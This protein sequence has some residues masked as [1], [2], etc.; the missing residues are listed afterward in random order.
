[1]LAAMI[2]DLDAKDANAHIISNS[3]QV[4]MFLRQLC[5]HRQHLQLSANAV[6]LQPA[7]LPL[8]KLCVSPV[9]AQ[10]Q[11]CTAVIQKCFDRPPLPLLSCRLPAPGTCKET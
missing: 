11:H 2:K 3:A 1:M 9:N 4:Q 5:M 10:T 8:K 7:E 6:N